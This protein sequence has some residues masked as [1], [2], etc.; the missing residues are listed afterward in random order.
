[1]QRPC[2]S[3]VRQKKSGHWV[4]KRTVTCCER[5]LS[6]RW[7]GFYRVHKAVGT[8]LLILVDLV[9]DQEHH[10]DQEGQSTH[11]QQGH[12]WEAHGG[13]ISCSKGRSGSKQHDKN[14]CLSGKWLV[15]PSVQPTWHLSGGYVT[16]PGVS[17]RWE[18][19]E[20]EE[21]G[22]GERQ[23]AEAGCCRA[24]VR[25]VPRSPQCFSRGF[26]RIISVLFI[27]PH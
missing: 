14:W 26:S 18:G 5:L 25:W 15:W 23:G 11:H 20:G 12:L 9:D 10:T 27:C 2:C 13:S 4:F 16:A 1:M 21:W 17:E 7:T 8:R 6:Y 3:K 24:V 22:E 19:R